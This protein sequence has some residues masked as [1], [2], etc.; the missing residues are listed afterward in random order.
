MALL[1]LVCSTSLNRAFRERGNV[2]VETEW[3]VE[4]SDSD[5]QSSESFESSLLKVHDSENLQL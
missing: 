3:T 5:S 4:P 1:M 2:V